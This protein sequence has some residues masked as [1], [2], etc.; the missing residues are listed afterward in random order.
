MTNPCSLPRKEENAVTNT[1]QKWRDKCCSQTAP[2][3]PSPSPSGRSFSPR[4]WTTLDS[5]PPLVCSVRSH[6]PLQPHA[7]FYAAGHGS[8]DPLQRGAAAGIQPPHGIPDP[9]PE[10]LITLPPGGLCPRQ[11]QVQ[12]RPR[13]FYWVQVRRIRRY[14][15][16]LQ[17][18]TRVRGHR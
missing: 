1:L 2:S 15:S 18:Y 13:I 17:P 6:R 12:H 16:A 14:L 10:S 4:L 7:R 9:R 3:S 5:T 11:A 8:D